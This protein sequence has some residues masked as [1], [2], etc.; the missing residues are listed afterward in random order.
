MFHIVPNVKN[1]ASGWWYSVPRLCQ[2]LATRGHD[3]ELACL[4]ARHNIAGVRTS[5]YPVFP[6]LKK[7]GISI[8]HTRAMMSAAK[9]VDLVHNHSLWSMMNIAAG[10]VVPRHR[11]KLVVSPRGTLAPA[12]LK[13]RAA[14]KTALWPIQYRTLAKADLLHS[15]SMDEYRD[16]RS[17]G[18]ANPV[19]VVPNGIDVPSLPTTRRT[20]GHRTLLFLSRIHPKK[21][22]ERLLSCWQRLYPRHPDWKLVIAGK[23]EPSYEKKLKAIAAKH[24]LERVRFVGPVYGAAKSQLYIQS[25]LFVLPTYNENFGNVVAEALV[26]RCPCVVTTGAPWAGL[27]TEGCGWWVDHDVSALVDALDAAMSRTED[28]L[29]EMGRRGR[30]WMVRDYGW[31]AM[32]LQMDMAYQWLL[33]R[34]E[35]PTCVHTA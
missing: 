9:R 27:Q 8:G 4:Y 15:T 5:D 24:R 34:G 11:A 29:Q 12:A 10:W 25:Q 7:L 30:A 19:A 1:E 16:I 13:F 28:T 20:Q 32:A 17:L 2:S 18:L 35:K 22:L 31:D 6:L 23:G 33:G 3:V 14:L 26:H 21:G